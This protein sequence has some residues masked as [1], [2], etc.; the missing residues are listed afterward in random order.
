[1]LGEMSLATLANWAQF[2]CSRPGAGDGTRDGGRVGALH[3]VGRRALQEAQDQ[4][5]LPAQR[6]HLHVDAGLRPRLQVSQSQNQQVSA[7]FR[8]LTKILN[9]VLL[10]LVL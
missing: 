1:M 5:H 4:P 6:P 2:V 8:N 9:H 3:G 7:R 10:K